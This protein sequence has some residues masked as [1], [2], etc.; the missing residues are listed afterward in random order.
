[1]AAADDPE[2]LARRVLRENSGKRVMVIGHVNTVPAIVAALSGKSDIPSV[3]EQDF[4]TMYVVT[5]P[6]IGRA[7]LLRLSY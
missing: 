5:V 3:D 1:V 6:S 4:A 2:G 7:N